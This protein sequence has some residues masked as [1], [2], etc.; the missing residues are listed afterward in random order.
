[1][2]KCSM[3][4]E[5]YKWEKF[6][7]RPESN[8]FLSGRHHKAVF[9]KSEEKIYL[10]GGESKTFI[11]D[12]KSKTWQVIKDVFINGEL[13]IEHCVFYANN[14]IHLIGGDCNASHP[15]WEYEYVRYTS[16]VYV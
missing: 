6:G 9:H 5:E 8:G 10:Y 14:A 15:V 12:I 7:K 16:C 3:D 13:I 4:Q 11:Y 1:M 2:Y